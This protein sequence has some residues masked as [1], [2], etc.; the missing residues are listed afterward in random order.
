MAELVLTIP[1]TTAGRIALTHLTGEGA[2]LFDGKYE[3]SLSDRLRDTRAA[4]ALSDFAETFHLYRVPDCKEWPS[5]T[6]ILRFHSYPEGGTPPHGYVS[7]AE[8]NSEFTLSAKLGTPITFHAANR[9]IYRKTLNV[10]AAAGD[11]ITGD[12][13]KVAVVDS[14]ANGVA[15]RD[16][17]DVQN[18][19]NVHPG[20][21][22]MVDNNGHGTAMANIISDVAPGA[23]LYAVRIADQDKAF[24]WDA[25]AGTALAVED[26]GAD[27]VNL[28]LG[29]PDFGI[30][31]CPICGSHAQVRS[32]AFEKLLLSLAGANA[33]RAVFVAAT[34]NAWA[35][36]GFDY[37]AAYLDTLAVGSVTTL[38]RRSSFS[39]YGTANH[40]RYVMAPGGEIDQATKNVT[41]AV[42]KRPPRLICGNIT[43][44]GLC[45]GRVG[46]AEIPAA[47]S[48]V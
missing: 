1:Q 6:A 7:G 25:M 35:S 48:R 19:T 5:I 21:G 13:I 11:G 20:A 36:N 12:P 10:D 2:A 31:P 37:P 45:L 9:L 40:P 46:F 15:L 22:A 30:S 27:I 16:F 44:G 26:C 42:G 17:Y 39:N 47:L 18:S 4:A 28:S 3:Q 34:G 8:F 23:H 33:S 29:F 41:E 14:G 32:I 43:C 24:L 38:E